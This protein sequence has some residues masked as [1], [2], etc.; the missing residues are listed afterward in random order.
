MQFEDRGITVP[1]FSLELSRQSDSPRDPLS[2]FLPSNPL[3]FKRSRYHSLLSFLSFILPSLSVSC[4]R[5][6]THTRAGCASRRISSV[7]SG[8][9]FAG[10]GSIESTQN[11]T[12]GR[13]EI[14]GGGRGLVARSSLRGT[15][16]AIAGGTTWWRISRRGE[17]E[18]DG[19]E[20]G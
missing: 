14:R 18:R 2:A 8:R 20:D 1:L 9:V 12:A 19:R 5:L 7:P 3:L 16:P 11:E 15:S 13:P 17:E 4:E 10:R 6:N